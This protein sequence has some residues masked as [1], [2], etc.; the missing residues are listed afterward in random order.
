[1]MPFAWASAS[2]RSACLAVSMAAAGAM[3]AHSLEA[4]A[5][6][7]A[8]EE[9]HRQIELAAVAGPEVEDRHRV[10][11]REE[12]VRAR[13]AQEARAARLVERALAAQDLDGHLAPD[14]RLL[15]AIHRAHGA[16]AELREHGEA[17][18][19]DAPDHRVALRP[20]ASVGAAAARRRRG[21][22]SC[23]GV[24]HE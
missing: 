1:M 14:R 24:G 10:G 4:L 2:D 7:L 9:L 22:T 8:L 19:D 5:E 16:R 11:R 17:A 21:I 13:L 3:R 18:R 15:R 20:P 6:R 23:G 12:A